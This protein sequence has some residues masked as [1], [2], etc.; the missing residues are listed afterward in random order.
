MKNEQEKKNREREVKNNDKKISTIMWKNYTMYRNFKTKYIMN[1]LKYT[2]AI[3]T[4]MLAGQDW[5]IN[6]NF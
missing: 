1:N 3:I 4:K 5:I 2:R 6:T